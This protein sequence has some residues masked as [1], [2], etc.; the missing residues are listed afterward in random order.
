MQDPKNLYSNPN[1]K[2]LSYRVEFLEKLFFSIT[3]LRVDINY[4]LFS[5]F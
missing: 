1:P 3:Y 5:L 2:G 4:Y